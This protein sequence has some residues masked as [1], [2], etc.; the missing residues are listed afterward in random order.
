MWQG[1]D[2][3]MAC[4]LASCLRSKAAGLQ[5][6]KRWEFKGRKACSLAVR[7]TEDLPF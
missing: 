6:R 5:R 2:C 1:N 3:S 4:D 7:L